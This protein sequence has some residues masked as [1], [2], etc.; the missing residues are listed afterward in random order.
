MTSLDEH[1]T[2]LEAEHTPRAVAERL[3]AGPRASH[4]RDIVYGA[5]DGTITTFA[6]VA[7]AVGAGL[8]SS[9][10]VVLGFA[11]LLADGFSMAVGNFLGTRAEDQARERTRRRE[12]AHIDMFPAGEREEIRQIFA[13]KGF[14]GAE[15][16]RVVEVITD[17]RELWVETMLREEHGLPMARRSATA[18]AVATFVAFLV[19]GSVPL[20][21]FVL[22]LAAPSVLP[23]P[24]AVSAVMTAG[25]FAAVGIAKSRAVDGSWRRDALETLALGGAASAIAFAVGYLLRGLVDAV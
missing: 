18:A 3:R 4:L 25:T 2:Q 6:I 15:L 11:N 17:D 5:I 14:A 13:A 24:V 10:V 9:V 7:G 8:P 19:V 12:Q 16:E 1:R 20:M 22:E 21:A 23:A